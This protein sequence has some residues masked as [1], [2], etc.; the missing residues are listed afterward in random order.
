[1]VSLMSFSLGLNNIHKIF[2]EVFSAIDLHFGRFMMGLSG[3]NSFEI[4][5]AAALVSRATRCGHVCL[6]LKSLAERPLFPETEGSAILPNL[7]S[8]IDSLEKNRSVGRP[9]E[10]KPLIIDDKARLYLYRYW[11]YERKLG[12]FIVRRVRRSDLMVN[13]DACNFKTVL[14]NYFPMQHLADEEINLKR[15]AAWL[16]VKRQFMVITGS[17]GTGKTTTAAKIIALLIELAADKEKIRIALAAPTGKAAV[18]LQEAV[19]KSLSSS[20]FSER[21]KAKMPRKATTI[22]RLL[23]WAY[24][25]PYF[26]HNAENPLPVD[27]VIVDEASMI[28]LPLMSKLVQALPE[29]AKLILLGDKDQLSSVEAGAV[30]GDI[31]ALNG[32]SGG[33]S[34]KFTEM[35]K[36]CTSE[37]IQKYLVLSKTTSGIKECIVEL[38]NNYRYDRESGIGVLAEAI[39]SGDINRIFEIIRSERYMDVDGVFFADE[40]NLHANLKK[41]AIEIFNDYI[42][43]IVTEKD[44]HVIFENLEKFRILCALRQG[45]FGVDA[46]NSFVQRILEE[47]NKIATRYKWYPGR[48]VMILRNDYHLRLFNGDIGIMLPDLK[49]NGELRAFFRNSDGALRSLPPS[50]LPEH[51]TAYAMTVHK[52]Q[53]SEF[54]SVLLILPDRDSP[55]LTRELLYTAVTRARNK[56]EIWGSESVIKNTV[57]RRIERTSGLRD[58]LSAVS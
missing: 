7:D 8:W 29:S 26:Y 14:D 21:V 52:S 6:D 53:G 4:F 16:A 28:D 40:Y 31:C 38:K 56:V 13:T 34:K 10:Y 51:E 49:E 12:D 48:P 47:N 27:V 20:S 33:Y 58:I 18:R 36:I 37:D 11:D 35:A 24:Y 9:G 23:G 43:L 17:P 41:K 2:G 50:A 1:M 57:F 46:I 44:Y 45:P 22:H 5:L 55:V 42:D 39:N 30:L 25:S 54:D 15:V 19:I 3:D 32:L